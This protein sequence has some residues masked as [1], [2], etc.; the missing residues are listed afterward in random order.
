MFE[1]RIQVK[2]RSCQ[3]IK[4]ILTGFVVV[5]ENIEP[6]VLMHRP[7]KLHFHFISFNNIILTRKNPSAINVK[8]LTY[9]SKSKNQ[10]PKKPKI[11]N[12]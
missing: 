8:Q 4:L 11:Q 1:E 2:I 9:N 7:R 12:S 3:V 6:S 5:Q 10:I